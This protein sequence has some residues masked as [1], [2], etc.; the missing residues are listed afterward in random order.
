MRLTRSFGKT[1]REAP[2]EAETASHRLLLRAG[3]IQPL[4]AGIY[5]SLPLGW[6]SQ[7]KIANIIRKEMNAAGG[8][9]VSMPVVQ[10][11]ELWE[12]SGRA[13]TFIPPLSGFEDRRGRA[14]VLA[15]THEEAI[16]EMVKANVHSY[17]DLPSTLYQIQTK[18]RDE[19]RPRAGLLRVR[20]FEMK[21]AYSFDA[22]DEGLDE[23]FNKMVRAYKR[24]FARCGIDVA[25]VEADSGGIGGKDSNEFILLAD[26]GEDVILLCDR[27]DYG[28]NVEKA[29]FKKK[30]LPPEA[31]LEIEEVHTPGVKTI[32]GLAEFLGI[33]TSKTIK[34]VFYTVDGEMVLVSIRGDLE[35]NEVKLRNALGGTEPRFAS[36]EQVKA[37]GLVAGSAS[38][39][40]LDGVRSIVDDSVQLGNNFVA[41]ANREDYHLLH[42]NFPRDFGAD[43]IVDI[44]T[45]RDGD[46]CPRC[47]GTLRDHRGIEVG[48]VFKLGTSYSE[49][50]GANFL[51]EGGHAQPIIMGCYGIGIGRLL[52]ATV[53]ANHDE[54][55]MILPRSIAPY[56]VYL[57]SLNVDDEKVVAAADGLYQELTARGI[58]ALYDDRDEKPGV[59]FNDADLIGSP[60]RVVVSRRGVANGEIE[61]KGRREQ[62][63]AFA[64]LSEAV[65]AVEAALAG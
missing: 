50:L 27:C 16:T 65:E 47:G 46:E 64:S 32:E 58:E 34:A 24:I 30:P 7:Q 17:R 61:L 55:G 36:A 19:P 57:A 49:S 59:K 22:T 29:E 10:P 18:F 15:P 25:M 45:A 26:S 2:A 9:E 35:V 12:R 62:K 20:E 42:V 63:P 56:E 53:E 60:L 52:A 40:G 38:A 43:E 5:S 13:D 28:A 39:A 1:L 54:R 48:H 3:F 37:A 41:G 4:A 14:M 31:P 51:D 11:R 21:D 8:Q 44:A 23:S 33:P 6:R